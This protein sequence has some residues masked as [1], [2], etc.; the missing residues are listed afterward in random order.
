[1][2]SF[3][4]LLSYRDEVDFGKGVQERELGAP[5]CSVLCHGCSRCQMSMTARCSTWLGASLF[6]ISV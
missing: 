3:V 6:F 2:I 1:M 5:V 4:S